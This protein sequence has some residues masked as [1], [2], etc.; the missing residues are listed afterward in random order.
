M[1]VVAPCGIIGSIVGFLVWRPP[2]SWL[3]YPCKA[4]GWI[5]SDDFESEALVRNARVLRLLSV[6]FQEHRL[7]RDAITEI[8]EGEAGRA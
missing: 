5:T 2:K 3:C 6:V 1:N 8:G 7:S 4:L